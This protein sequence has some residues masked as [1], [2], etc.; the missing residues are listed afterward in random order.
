MLFV[1]MVISISCLMASLVFLTM[2]LY[3]RKSVKR[4]SSPKECS[5]SSNSSSDVSA[6]PVTIATNGSILKRSESSNLKH[7]QQQQK[8]PSPEHSK[9]R[10]TSEP[11][12]FD[13]SNEQLLEDLQNEGL[14]RSPTLMDYNHEDKYGFLG[15]QLF[16]L[17]SINCGNSD[18]HNVQ[19]LNCAN[20]GSEPIHNC[21]HSHSL[22]QLSSYCG[23]YVNG[24]SVNMVYP[25]NH[26]PPAP[27]TSSTP[28]SNCTSTTVN[29]NSNH[30][31]NLQLDLIRCSEP[32]QQVPVSYRT[33]NLSGNNRD[34]AIHYPITGM[35]AL[36]MG[37]T[38]NRRG[39]R[40]ASM[41]P[42]PIPQT[43]FVHNS[44]NNTSSFNSPSKEMT[45]KLG[46]NAVITNV[47]HGE[48]SCG[49]GGGG[50]TL[51]KIVIG[52]EN[53]DRF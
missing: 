29:S 1:L 50:S 36:P 34:S 6:N 14:V 5:L 28:V 17:E 7:T 51:Q 27:S 10:L 25:L 21:V 13:A 46:D 30:S 18:R 12:I 26:Y 42:F 44:S 20:L 2:I 9:H 33:L 22:H 4:E 49:G 3:S 48:D 31:Q 11:G 35:A 16:Q 45:L 39:S 23:S 8:I 52:N 38:L 40:I 15:N 37:G 24:N 53:R 43:S 19:E 47:T 32:S 41:N